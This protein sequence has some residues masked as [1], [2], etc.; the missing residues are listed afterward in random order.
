M[1]TPS[2]MMQFTGHPQQQQIDALTTW[3]KLARDGAR[4]RILVKLLRE[5]KNR[6]SK[7]IELDLINAISGYEYLE[8]VTVFLRAA[9]M[10]TA[11]ALRGAAF[12]VDDRI[13]GSDLTTLVVLLLV[14][15]SAGDDKGIST[16]AESA[17]G[18]MELEADTHGL[19]SIHVLSIDSESAG[20]SEMLETTDLGSCV[21]LIFCNDGEIS[22]LQDRDLD[23]GCDTTPSDELEM[24][25]KSISGSTTCVD[26]NSSLTLGT[27]VGEATSIEETS[28]T[29]ERLLLVAS[30]ADPRKLNKLV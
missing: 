23:T 14:G 7:T 12:E 22:G 2:I 19:N 16:G 26:E 24:D 3:S 5:P 28:A 25:S 17:R 8:T 18:D 29:L 13:T 4:D 20:D 21:T 27:M 15:A 10:S 11:A 9:A 30:S 1:K 6:E